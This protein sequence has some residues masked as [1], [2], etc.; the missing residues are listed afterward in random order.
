MGF[1]TRICCTKGVKKQRSST[2]NAN[3]RICCP[4]LF[5]MEGYS[6]ILPCCFP[7]NT[8]KNPILSFSY[9]YSERAYL[10]LEHYYENRII[11][12]RNGPICGIGK[13]L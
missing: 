9:L 2:K 3:G 7:D 10:Q 12:G 6:I 8:K 13:L 5:P 11:F 1:P 4:F